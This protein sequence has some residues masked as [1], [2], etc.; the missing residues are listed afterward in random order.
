MGKLGRRAAYDKLNLAILYSGK[1]G[2]QTVAAV[3]LGPKSTL[4]T[5]GGVGV[6]S[7]EAAVKAALGEPV[8]DPFI[9][10]WWYPAKG[11]TLQLES[12]KV[13]AMQVLPVAKKSK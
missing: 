1:T 2:A 3:Y 4:K 6:G 12:G 13:V 5:S 8:K 9:G 11:L 10:A 7:G